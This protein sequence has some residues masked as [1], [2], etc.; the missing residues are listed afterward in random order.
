[1]LNIAEDKLLKIKEIE[2]KDKIK[3]KFFN[4]KL[5]ELQYNNEL[6]SEINNL[7]SILSVINQIKENFKQ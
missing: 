1:M 7:F 3:E 4:N 2:V 6:I 5:K